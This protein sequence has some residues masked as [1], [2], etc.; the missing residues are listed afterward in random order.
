MQKIILICYFI[1]HAAAG[2][3]NSGLFSK[4][5]QYLPDPFCAVRPA[6]FSLARVSPEFRIYTRQNFTRFRISDTNNSAFF[7]QWLNQEGYFA[8]NRQVA[9][10]VHGYIN[11]GDTPW[12][13][14]MKDEILKAEDST[15]IIVDWSIGA[16]P[17]YA[18]AASNTRT[19]AQAIASFAEA[20]ANLKRF[21]GDT[22]QLYLY[23]IGHSLGAQVCG[24]AGRHAK[25]ASGQQLF[26]RVTGL[27]PAGP[28][29]V[30]CPDALHIDKDS[31]KCVDIIHTDGS[32]KGHISPI[33]HYGTLSQWGH[34]DFYPNGGNNQPGCLSIKNDIGFCS[35]EKAHDFFMTTIN[36]PDSC[37]ATGLCSDVTSIPASCA[38]SITQKM[39]YYSSCHKKSAGVIEGAFYL[40]ASA[41][42]PLCKIEFNYSN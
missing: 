42:E 8:Q 1:N 15:V 14:P 17:P 33:V 28:G 5:N 25:S 29:F 39:G 40:A 32:L 6:P 3:I 23:C 19:A 36:R 12:V 18:T 7:A 31:A 24:Q 34:V 38:S 16:K 35:H 37:A 30:K 2:L 20:V 27:D 21:S 41:S 9:F 11:N 4:V 26:N 10:I 13:H 22:S